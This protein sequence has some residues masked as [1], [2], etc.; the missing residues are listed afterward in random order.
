MAYRL[1]KSLV[2]LRAAVNAAAPLRSRVSDGWI[3]DL[4]HSSRKS[5]HNPNAAGVVTA[6]DI[7]NDPAHGVDGGAIAKALT[8]DP[9]VKYVIWNR[10]IW[11]ASKPSWRPYTGKNPHTKHVHVS[12]SAD[13]AKYDDDKTPWTMSGVPAVPHGK[14]VDDRPTLRLKS[15]GGE[16]FDLQ[17]KLG[18]KI[19][20]DF[21]PKTEAAVKAFQRKNKLE[22]D[23]V[24][25]PY[26]WDALDKIKLPEA[27]PQELVEVPRAADAVGTSRWAVAK[28]QELGLSR[29]SSVALVANLMWESGGKGGSIN[30][31]AHGDNNHSHGAGQWNDRAGRFQELERFAAD[32]GK[33]WDDPE[34]QLRFMVDELNTTE[35]HARECLEGATTV[36]EKV[37]AALTY[38]RPSIPHTDKRLAI[39]EKLDKEIEDVA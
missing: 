26:T 8:A 20:G 4:A 18:L 1:A 10:K 30:W 37:E 27:P 5:D 2:A 23:G 31:S 19:D 29:L 9:R 38:W 25:G 28:L 15:Q 7:T 12:A 11:S 22:I 16:V 36:K 17:R 32:R 21:G 39:A 33:T 24:V 6:L 3:G 34:T 35:V 13:K 14:P